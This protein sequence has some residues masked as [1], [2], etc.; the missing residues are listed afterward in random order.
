ML[1]KLSCERMVRLYAEGAWLNRICLISVC[2]YPDFSDSRILCADCTN[3]EENTCGW[4]R[5]RGYNE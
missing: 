5:R 3:L 1:F 2:I 4:C